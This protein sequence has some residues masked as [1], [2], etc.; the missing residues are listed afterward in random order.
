M[1]D[2]NGNIWTS[3]AIHASWVDTRTG[4]AQD[5]TGGFAP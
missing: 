5:W 2:Y 1:G 4:V 3:E